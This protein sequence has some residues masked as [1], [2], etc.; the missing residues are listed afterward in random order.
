[1]SKNNNNSR[2]DD[3][4]GTN[5]NDK[6]MALFPCQSEREKIVWL[7]YEMRMCAMCVCTVLART[8]CINY[9]GAFQVLDWFILYICFSLSNFQIHLWTCHVISICY[10]FYTTQNS[11]STGKRL[12][13]ARKSMVFHVFISVEFHTPSI[14]VNKI[15]THTQRCRSILC[16]ISTQFEYY[17]WVLEYAFDFCCCCCF[18]C[19][20]CHNYLQPSVHI[21]VCVCGCYYVFD[22]LT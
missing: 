4:I 3:V 17:C 19:W 22:H 13:C 16:L 20:S 21:R 1:M 18:C 7:S 8:G 6:N 10:M 5:R 11:R 12:L 15:H 2:T 9:V 14:N